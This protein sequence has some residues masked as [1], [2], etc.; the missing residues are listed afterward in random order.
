MIIIIIIIVIIIIIITEVDEVHTCNLEKYLYKIVIDYF[1][2]PLTCLTDFNNKIKRH[3]VAVAFCVLSLT[4]SSQCTRN[5]LKEGLIEGS[6]CQ[7]RDIICL[8]LGSSS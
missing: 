1:I 6:W 4:F 5:S 8:Q 7:Q 2:I 3:S